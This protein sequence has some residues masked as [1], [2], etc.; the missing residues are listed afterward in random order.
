MPVEHLVGEHLGR[1][2]RTSRASARLE[3]PTAPTEPQ[4]S[5]AHLVGDREGSR[6][7]LLGALPDP[8]QLPPKGSLIWDNV[9]SQGP[10]D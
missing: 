1:V 5:C 8:V 2:L 9:T 7:L 4:R 10:G 3:K 6:E